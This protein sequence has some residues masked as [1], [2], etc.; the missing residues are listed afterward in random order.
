[1]T[2]DERSKFLRVTITLDD[3]PARVSGT[4]Q[5]LA[6]IITIERD[7]N[8]K[9]GVYRCSWE[10]VKKI[11]EEEEGRFYGGEKVFYFT[12][13]EFIK[14][15]G[16]LHGFIGGVLVFAFLYSGLELEPRNELEAFGMLSLAFFVFGPVIAAGVAHYQHRSFTEAAV[17]ALVGA[18]FI[19]FVGFLFA[20]PSF[21]LSLIK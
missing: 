4:A 14:E 17:Q 9:F 1:M 5:R 2:L 11:V 21:V 8:G 19:L 20:V 3:K 18:F 13:D 7:Q 16:A 10:E 15:K 12:F 6:E